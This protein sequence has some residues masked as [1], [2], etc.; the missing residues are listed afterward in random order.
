MLTKA[1]TV[2]DW[3]I[4][5]LAVIAAALIAF[6][7]LMV[8]T[9]VVMRYFFDR[10]L[11]AVIEIAEYCLLFITFLAVTWVLKEEKHV[12]LD[13]LTNMLKPRTRALVNITTSAICTIACIILAVYGVKV[14]W[15]HFAY[16]I[17]FTSNL[18]P[19]A[20][21]IIAIV[22]VGY[23]VLFPQFIRRTLGF[24]KDYR[25]EE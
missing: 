20:Y 16:N 8:C 6:L 19:P 9:E 3:T 25:R 24:F 15:E 2:L 4:K 1:I 23:L 18:M 22:P 5:V 11:N 21:L 7:V 12:K 14:T 10:P 13:V 17:R